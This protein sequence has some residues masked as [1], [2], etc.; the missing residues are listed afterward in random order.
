MCDCCLLQGGHL[1]SQG[2]FDTPLNRPI[3]PITTPATSTPKHRPFGSSTR[4]S[5]TRPPLKFVSSGLKRQPPA[6]KASCA[7]ANVHL[8]GGKSKII[9]TPGIHRTAIS[10]RECSSYQDNAKK[11]GVPPERQSIASRKQAEK[12]GQL[13]IQKQN[14]STAQKEPMTKASNLP[15]TSCKRVPQTVSKE[16]RVYSDPL[17][18]LKNATKKNEVEKILNSK[19]TPSFQHLDDSSE[20]DSP[21]LDYDPP[22][23]TTHQKELHNK[24]ASHL[25]SAQLKSL[26]STTVNKLDRGFVNTNTISLTSSPEIEVNTNGK[27]SPS[28]IAATAKRNRTTGVKSRNQSYTSSR[29]ALLDIS[30]NAS[31]NRRGQR[32]EFN[33]SAGPQ[34][35]GKRGRNSRGK[36]QTHSNNSSFNNSCDLDAI[37]DSMPL[38][39]SQE[40]QVCELENENTASSKSHT[41]R[42]SS[43]RIQVPVDN[44]SFDFDSDPESDKSWE[45]TQKRKKGGWKTGA[46]KV[47]GATN[48]KKKPNGGTTTAK[49]LLSSSRTQKKTKNSSRPALS[50]TTCII[51]P[52]S[53]QASTKGSTA[54]DS[55]QTSTV[56]ARKKRSVDDVY[57]S[58][59]TPNPESSRSKVTQKS[60]SKLSL[61]KKDTAKATSTTRS[62]PPCKPTKQPAAKTRPPIQDIGSK[63]QLTVTPIVKSVTRQRVT[64]TS[65]SI[66]DT[67]PLYTL[68]P[69]VESSP[70]KPPPKKSIPSKRTASST[71][72]RPLSVNLDLEVDGLDLSSPSPKKQRLE[73]GRRSSGYYSADVPPSSTSSSVDD[74]LVDDNQDDVYSSLSS[75]DQDKNNNTPL[76]ITPAPAAIEPVSP[77][78]SLHSSQVE[79]DSN[80]TIGF[81]QI[82]RNLIAQSGKKN[83]GSRQQV[84][85]LTAKKSNNVKEKR[86]KQTTATEKRPSSPITLTQLSKVYVHGCRFYV[87]SYYYI[88]SILEANHS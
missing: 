13:Q 81:Q 63:N 40:V 51:T 65:K 22:N 55:K 1:N 67:S 82:C 62:N 16:R 80:V 66:W 71:K 50:E 74:S 64:G 27:K 21:V 18:K 85:I 58:E 53:R 75:L 7:I 42:R 49:T 20:V 59:P 26:N 33:L 87:H 41:L 8:M 37:P 45:L 12:S 76:H 70:F 68:D 56:T 3:P 72:K 14:E 73:K 44:D 79:A 54:R 5:I 19:C 36:N 24:S 30:N 15:A 2:S 10:T 6:Q 11:N 39:P 57:D 83:K 60:S 25:E 48:K 52:A 86:Q 47:T 77:S 9:S 46:N 69:L 61:S 32:R 4:N 78:S 31:L 34:K 35:K 43:K 88:V 28:H 17:A 23:R 84:N 29:P 38:T